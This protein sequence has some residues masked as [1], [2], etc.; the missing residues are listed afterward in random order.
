MDNITK[1]I[2]KLSQK[3]QNTLIECILKIEN[4]DI[5]NQDI[6]KLSGFS[7]TYRFRKGKFRIVFIK[8]ENHTQIINISYRK[9]AY[10]K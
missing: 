10:K 2:Q 5:E 1:F 7:D 4:N 9:D 3:E 6:K 8:S